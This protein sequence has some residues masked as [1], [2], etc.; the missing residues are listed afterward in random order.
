MVFKASVRELNNVAGLG[1]KTIAAIKSFNSK[2]RVEKEI[3]FLNKYQVSLI[4]L[5]DVHYPQNLFNIYDPPPIL[6]VKG[7]IK[8]E[9]S[10]ALAIVGSR[11]ASLYGR[12]IT[13]KISREM[14][15]RR[16]TV[17]SGMARG[18]DTCAHQGVLSARG[19][20]IAVMGCGIDIIYPSENRELWEKI[21][22]NG[23]VISE[24]PFSTP[25]DKNNFPTRNRIISGLSLG[26]V[27]VEASIISGSLI[28]ARSAMDQGREVF[29]VPGNVNSQGSKG[30]N[31]LI[32]E[33]A[34]LVTDVND[35]FEDI[36]PQYDDGNPVPQPSGKEEEISEI[37][38]SLCPEAGMIL[39]ALSQH[40]I[41]VDDII[42]KTKLSSSEV[43]CQLLDLELKGLARQLP[44]KMF[45]RKE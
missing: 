22:A 41:H 43:L 29:A 1:A 21:V 44:G 34:K 11:S 25:P 45:L 33:G 7:V 6:Y 23:A 20:T 24:F 35:I 42:V 32:K 4:T 28:T 2:E 19:R 30:T 26:V 9:D 18:I 31:H 36:Y 17:V 40:P 13:E 14:A 12:L 15:R 38:A 16:V 3:Y 39:A 8:K 5:G 27:V 10:F 37:A